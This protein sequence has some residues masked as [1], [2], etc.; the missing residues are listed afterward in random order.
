MFQRVPMGMHLLSH[1][2]QSDPAPGWAA[3]PVDTRVRR[4]SSSVTEANQLPESSYALCVDD[5]GMLLMDPLAHGFGNLGTSFIMVQANVLQILA[6]NHK[7]TLLSMLGAPAMQRPRELLQQLLQ[8]W[9]EEQQLLREPA[10]S[11]VAEEQQLL[12][13]PA[14]ST[15]AEARSSEVLRNAAGSTAEDEA[16][17]SISA[18]EQQLLSRSAGAG[19]QPGAGR[20]A[21]SDRS[22][23][24]LASVSFDSVVAAFSHLQLHH[25]DIDFEGC[26]AEEVI[27]SVHGVLE[28]VVCAEMEKAMV[29]GVTADQLLAEWVAAHR[30]RQLR[31][32]TEAHPLDNLDIARQALQL[33]DE[34]AR[35]GYPSLQGISH[36]AKEASAAAREH[37]QSMEMRLASRRA[38]RGRPKLVISSPR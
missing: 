38:A 18:N 29:Q 36:L 34:A 7:A 25:A 22:S 9:V 37:I 27:D 32:L 1:C 21:G 35:V 23:G 17:A 30:L 26:T 6:W 12:R 19:Q 14:E 16:A 4:V 31:N 5:S 13:G 3:A 15:A 33:F 28:A 20:G 2:S 8:L 24:P 10:E 11:T